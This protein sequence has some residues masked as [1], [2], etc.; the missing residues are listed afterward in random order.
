[1]NVGYILVSHKTKANALIQ[2]ICC[3]MTHGTIT[4][5]LLTNM[6]MYNRSHTCILWT[7]LDLRPLTPISGTTLPWSQSPTLLS[8]FCPSVERY[9][10]AKNKLHFNYGLIWPDIC[11]SSLN[12]H[13]F[14]VCSFGPVTGEDLEGFHRAGKDLT[15]WTCRYCLRKP[16]RSTGRQQAALGINTVN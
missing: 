5:T 4:S 7:H 2:I 14:S 9:Q 8:C 3:K 12:K 15:F 13:T 6:A 16:V 1:M 10:P 11:S